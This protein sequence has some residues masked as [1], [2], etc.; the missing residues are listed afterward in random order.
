MKLMQRVNRLREKRFSDAAVREFA[1]S[2]GA[3]LAGLDPTSVAVR[4]DVISLLANEAPTAKSQLALRAI[5]DL[6]LAF[7]EAQQKE[8]EMQLSLASIKAT[9]AE[10]VLLRLLRGDATEE[11]IGNS[12]LTPPLGFLKVLGML[13]DSGYISRIGPHAQA[14]WKEQTFTLSARGRDCAERLQFP[15]GRP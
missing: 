2:L 15:H 5:A 3:G 10:H 1:Q 6:L 8:Q 9:G 7:G 12:I 11:Q 14:P 13:N 4:Q